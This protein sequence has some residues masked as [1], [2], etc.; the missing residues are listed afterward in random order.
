ML[1]FFYYNKVIVYK[2]ISLVSLNLGKGDCLDIGKR[3]KALR[4]K[5]G[6]TLEELASRCELTK[7]FLSQLEN[8]LTSPSISTLEDIT[9]VLGVSLETFFKEEKEEQIRFN[10]DDY[11]VDEK[12]KSTITWLVPNAQKNEME[13][14]HL[15]L[16]YKGESSEIEPHE[17]EEFAYVLEGK[18]DLIDLN[19]K[20]KITLKK[21]ETFYLKGNFSHK[22]VNNSSRWQRSYGSQHHRYFKGRKWKN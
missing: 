2:T 7:G 10:S 21:G 12:D 15:T 19:S 11:F 16:Q 4:T 20:K 17:G 22:I 9:E 8:N 6:L 18:V 14:I 3:I 1:A 5:S 13:P